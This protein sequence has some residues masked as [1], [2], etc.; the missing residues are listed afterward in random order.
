[1]N[2]ETVNSS[3]PYLQIG[4]GRLGLMIN[5]AIKSKSE[6]AK[7][8]LSKA[9]SNFRIDP[10]NGLSMALSTAQPVTIERLLICIAPGRDK[11]WSW[12]NIFSGLERQVL[13]KQLF[14][15]ELIFISSTRVYD[16]IS[17]GIVTAQDHPIAQSDRAKGIIEAE[18]QLIRLAKTHCI[19]RC[20]GLIGEQYQQF[21]T[22]LKQEDGKV[23]FAVDIDQV[24][25]KVVER[26]ATTS[27]SN[28]YSIVTDGSCY[29]QGRRLAFEE[30]IFLSGEH[31]LLQQS[32]CF[33]QQVR[34]ENR[35]IKNPEK[36]G[37]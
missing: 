6:L 26:L 14:I 17:Q 9:H 36:P 15:N 27:S 32:D 34:A 23:R 29:Y 22:Y 10:V 25:T 20:C 24:A 5:S 11:K 3:I 12:S 30:S 37:F 18:K 31:R 8:L 21:Q 19:L 4:A 13:Q 16:G 7:L 35:V 1:M 28:Q 33:K 2:N